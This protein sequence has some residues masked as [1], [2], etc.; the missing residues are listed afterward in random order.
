MEVKNQ[1]LQLVAGSLNSL[2][3]L[4][5]QVVVTRGETALLILRR[6]QILMTGEILPSRL[7]IKIGAPR[8]CNK[9]YY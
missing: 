2:L 7:R 3:R 9:I 1:L 5:S 6:Q 8:V 4:Q